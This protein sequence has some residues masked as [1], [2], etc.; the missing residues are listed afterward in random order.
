M[1]DATLVLHMLADGI[2]ASVAHGG[3]EEGMGTYALS[4][5]GNVD[6][7]MSFD[8]YFGPFI[9]HENDQ[10]VGLCLV[11][12]G[13]RLK[14]LFEGRHMV[15]CATVQDETVDRRWFG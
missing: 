9:T 13:N 8:G 7:A 4:M 15:S 12:E 11:I 2:E 3:N 6:I 5:D 1:E 10:A 14:H